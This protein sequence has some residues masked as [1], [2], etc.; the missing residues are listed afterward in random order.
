MKGVSIPGYEG[1][2]EAY[3][4]GSIVSIKSACTL[5][6]GK[7]SVGY[8]RVNLYKN[9]QMR[10]MFVHRIIAEL[11]VPN[12]DNLPV[13]NHID[14]NKEN[15]SADN[16]E[17]CTQKTNIAHSRNLGNQNKDVPVHAL[18]MLTGEKRTFLNLKSAGRELFGKWWALMHLHRTQGDAFCKNEWLFKCGKEVMCNHGI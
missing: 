14:A 6:P 11:F 4:D 9:K 12:P 15:N 8:L 10:H 1:L 18:N 13:V 17:W 5:K 16:L 3:P 7:N 2:Y